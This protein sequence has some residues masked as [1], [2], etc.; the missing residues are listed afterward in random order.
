M[1]LIGVSAVVYVP[2]A[3]TFTPWA[4]AEFGPFAFQV[5]FA[6][7]FVVY[8]FSGLIVGAGGLECGLLDFQGMLARRAVR[9]IMAALVV[10]LIWL[11]AMAAVVKDLLPGLPGRQMA[12]DLATVLFVGCACFG[13]LAGFLR[14]V[15]A[16]R[17]I[18]RSLAQNG[19]GIYFF[20]Y[21][22]ILWSQYLLLGIAAFALVKAAAVFGFTLALSWAASAAIR[23][24]FGLV[25]PSAVPLRAAPQRPLPQL[26]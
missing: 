4:W 21:F 7:Q 6:P 9:W 23:L 14:F 8:F 13:S 20:H 24:L 19:Y 15:N 26:R 11:L 5:S 12:A 16:R 2:L 22:F 25:A 18:L 3:R 10:F 1:V 17:R